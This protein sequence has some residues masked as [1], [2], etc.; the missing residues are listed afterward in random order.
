MDTTNA[1]F[2]QGDKSFPCENVSSGG[3]GG[4]LLKLKGDD[5]QEL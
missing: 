3:D 5:L 2:A 4:R 1:S